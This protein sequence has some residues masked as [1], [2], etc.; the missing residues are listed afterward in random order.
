MPYKNSFMKMFL[1]IIATF[2]PIVNIFKV[3]NIS[4]RA[5]L[6]SDI[7]AAKRTSTFVVNFIYSTSS[8]ETV[9]KYFAINLRILTTD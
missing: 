4:Y 8:N 2:R 9:I 5:I 1:F 6:K 3:G 7:L